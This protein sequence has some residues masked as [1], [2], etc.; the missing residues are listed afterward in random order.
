MTLFRSM[1]RQTLTP[2]EITYNASNGQWPATKLP[3]ASNNLP[4][5]VGEFLGEFL[6]EVLGEFL[7]TSSLQCARQPKP[8]SVVMR[9][10][11]LYLRFACCKTRTFLCLMLFACVQN[12]RD[13]FLTFW[14]LGAGCAGCARCAGCAGGVLGAPSSMGALGARCARCAGCD[15]CAGC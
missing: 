1:Q 4:S 11:R 15:E 5:V 3:A 12:T 6:G 7:G 13:P 9:S 10:R 8:M 14:V 2:N